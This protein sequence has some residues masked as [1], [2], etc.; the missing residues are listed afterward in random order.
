MKYIVGAI[1]LFLGV[2]VIYMENVINRQVKSSISKA[3]KFLEKGDYDY[4]L[5]EIDLQT[6]YSNKAVSEYFK[7]KYNYPLIDLGFNRQSVTPGYKENIIEIRDKIN[8]KKNGIKQQAADDKKKVEKERKEKARELAKK[9]KE[10]KTTQNSSSSSSSDYE[11]QEE[12]EEEPYNPCDD[13]TYKLYEWDKPLETRAEGGYEYMYFIHCNGENYDS[14]TL[15]KNITKHLPTYFSI[16]GE[17]KH[18]DNEYSAVKY[19]C[20]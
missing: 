10:R 11:E 16:A 9:E 1:L 3:E 8:N 14:G 20:G 6:K 5:A 17:Y 7:K 2:R 19:A 15:I 13:F 12:Q 18:Y 4:A